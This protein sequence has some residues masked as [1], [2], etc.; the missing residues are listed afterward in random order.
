MT[1]FS[2]V[3]IGLIGWKY[4]SRRENRRALVFFIFVS[5][6]VDLD[7]LLYYLLGKP[8]IF[9]HQLYTHNVFVSLAVAFVFFPFLN[10][11]RERRGLAL[12][13]VSH[14]VMDVF[15]IDT[16]APIGIRPFY[17]VSNAFFSYGFFP[18]VV[19]GGWAEVFSLRN[20]FALSLEVA[21]FIVPAVVLCRK[22]LVFL[23][24]GAARESRA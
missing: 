22:E 4:S 8:E 17:P 6:A 2:H 24:R 16:I 13:A 14:L 18:Y 1:P 3:A 20:V 5:C 19:R 11:A 21:V 23:G 12:V 10:T 7:F 15:V 9:A